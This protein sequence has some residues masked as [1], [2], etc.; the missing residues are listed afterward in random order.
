M[1]P[2]A[3]HT[4]EAFRNFILTRSDEVS[5][6]WR[7][8]ATTRDAIAAISSTCPLALR[9]Y[10]KYLERFSARLNFSPLSVTRPGCRDENLTQT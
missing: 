1:K 8:D 2:D 7:C 9:H 3:L 6:V 4:V 10:T 5:S